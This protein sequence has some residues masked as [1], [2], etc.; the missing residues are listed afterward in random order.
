LESKQNGYWRNT[1]ESAQIIETLLHDIIN[2]K[3]AAGKPELKLKG[4]VEKTITKFPFELKIKPEQKIE[5]SKIGDYPIY[6][7]SYQKYWNKSPEA[8]SNDFEISTYFENC[9]NSTLKA[10]QVTKL[11]TKVK[12]K[13][14]AEYVMINIPIPAGCS[15]SDKSNNFRNESHREYFK[16]ETA[17]FCNYLTKG[18]YTFVVELVSRYSGVYTVNPAKIE[19]MY[20]PVFNANNEVKT[21]IIK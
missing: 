1:Y 15:Y 18:E 8:K 7:T 14:D 6:L 13:K 21:V 19:L 11:I 10:G 5:V 12:L 2:G 16:N 4:D 3:S 20:F 9:N 17:I